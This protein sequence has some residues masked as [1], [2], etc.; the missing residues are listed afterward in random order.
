MKL[1][2]YKVRQDPM[3]MTNTKSCRP[4]QLTEDRYTK[5]RVAQEKVD[6]LHVNWSVKFTVS[7]LA[8]G[9]LI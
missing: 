2:N 9:S 8:D 6:L 7:K 4:L 5:K 3:A 1:V